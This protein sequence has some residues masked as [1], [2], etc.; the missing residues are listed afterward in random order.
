MTSADPASPASSQEASAVQPQAKNTKWAVAAGGVGL[1]ALWYVASLGQ[2][3]L[4]LPSPISTAEALWDLTRSG[5]L[6]EQLAGTLLRCLLGV[7]L[8]LVIGVPWGLA[9]GLSAFISGISEVLLRVLMAVPPVL[10]VVVAMIWLGPGPAAVV[11]VTTLV[12]LPLMVVTTREAVLGVDVD[13]LEMGRAFRLG[14]WTRLRHIVIPASTPA[15]LAGVSV[16]LGQSIRITVMAELLAASTGVGNEL[17]LSRTNL[18]T[19]S[20]FAWAVVLAALAFVIEMGVVRP[21]TRRSG[22]VSTPQS[23]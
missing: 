2:P 13:L 8:A 14:L 11:L 16:L 15:V 6:A 3:G 10:F 20:L 17:A 5:V 9:A 23:V 7:G 12:G 21:L 4:L 19:S 18:E 1:V 22:R